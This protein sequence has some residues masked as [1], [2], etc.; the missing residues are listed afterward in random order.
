[1]RGLS[2]RF[3]W[4]VWF[5][6]GARLFCLVIP[7]DCFE[8]VCSQDWS[9]FWFLSTDQCDAIGATW[10]ALP[11]IT[12]GPTHPVI[13]TRGLLQSWN[14][15]WLWVIKVD[16]ECETANSFIAGGVSHLSNRSCYGLYSMVRVSV[17]MFVIPLFGRLYRVRVVNGCGDRSRD[18]RDGAVE[19]FLCGARARNSHQI[20]AV[21]CFR[22][23][24]VLSEVPHVIS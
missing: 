18:C 6:E 9:I 23:A 11:C 7:G 14:W 21:P 5:E 13:R 24:V 2:T 17:A 22:V 12:G 10:L 1:M 3:H 8:C 4:Q 19:W 16:A 15:W 20:K